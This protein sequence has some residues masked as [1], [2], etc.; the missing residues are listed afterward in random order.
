MILSDISKIRLRNQQIE[1]SISKTPKELVGWMG[2]MQAQDFL[3]LKWAVGLRVV[4]STEASFE[5][6]YNQGDI[7]RT[8][9]LR[10]TWHLVAQEDVYW[11]LHLTAPHILSAFNSN[12]KRLELTP[13]IFFKSNNL[14]EKIFSKGECLT[15][16]EIIPELNANSIRTDENRLSHLLMAA[17]LDEIICSGPLKNGKLTYSLFSDRITTRTIYNRQEAIAELAR[18]YFGSHSP[19][20]LKDFIWW[21][22]LSITAARKGLES[23]KHNLNSEE[24][25]G[26]TYWFTDNSWTEQEVSVQL[27]PAFDEFLIAYRDRTATITQSDNKKAISENGLFRPILV[28]DGQVTGLWKRTVKNHKVLIEIDL[29]QV[30]DD[31]TKSLIEVKAQQYAD[32][33][34]KIPEV[35]FKTK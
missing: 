3:M 28:I 29:F 24:I 22:G 7:I 16:E 1:F 19:A 17:E 18:R 26:E 6:S 33:L 23:I 13:D 10:P 8:H 2:A 25:N 35:F 5:D 21:S 11:I 4:N 12:N 9:L 14:L 20:S 27:L 15:R 31:K 32:F 34:G 30:V